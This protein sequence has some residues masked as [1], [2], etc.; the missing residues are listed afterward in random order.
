MDTAQPAATAPDPQNG[1]LSWFTR[2]S[3]GLGDTAMNIVAG[4]MT[5]LTFFYTDYAGVEPTTVGLVFLLSRIFDGISDLI[6]GF[7]VERT[8]SK[9][10]KSRPWILWSSIPFCI[11]IVLIYTVP[12]GP[13]FMKFVYLFITYNFCN[14]VCYTALNLP[15]GSL[16]AMMTRISRERDMLSIT[17]MALSP[18]GKI[19]SISAT[20]PLIK[21]LGDNQAAWIKVMSIWAVL[22]FVLLMLCFSQCKE[23]VVIKA[24]KKVSKVPVVKSL[25][26]LFGNKYFWMAMTI[27]MMQC[28]IQMVTGTVLPYYC[29]YIFHDD[30]LFSILLLCE[31]I[32]TIVCTIL[33][34]PSLLK[35]FGKRN[36]SLIGVVVALVGHLIYCLNPTSFSWV[37]FSCIIRGIG[38]APLN[39]V[40]FG[41]LG[42]VVEYG[43]WKFHVRQ[44]GLIFSGGSVGYKVGTGITGAF[45][46]VL[47][48]WS[49]YISSS[50]ADAVQPQSAIDMIV[51]M[52]MYG[53]I[54][55][56][57]ILLIVLLCYQLDKLYPKIMRD[58]VDREAHG[59]L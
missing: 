46:T 11:S 28:I 5:I 34:C 36:M 21:V 55:I 48:S 9:W 13:D 45:I 15:Y 37:V 6:M 7:V 26:C 52:Y 23:T 53:M 41:F 22:A 4:A 54:I 47:M 29:K 8:N 32:T 27:W 44:E 56:W 58:L 38:F 2:I 33:F 16:S 19:I 57:V 50:T 42:D 17:R 49:G 43:Q 51:N 12:Q 59:E 3:Y 1:R 25:K 14:T 18:I 20:L 31:V 30:S 39:S 35:R 24:R 10:G 40:I